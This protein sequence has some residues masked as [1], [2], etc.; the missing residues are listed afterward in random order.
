MTAENMSDARA[1][2]ESSVIGGL[3]QRAQ[4][5]GASIDKAHIQ[6][7]DILDAIFHPSVRWSV[8]EYLKEISKD[9][10]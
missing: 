3:S 6:V 4:L 9:S 2:L 5:T 8:V 10:T 1:T 7:P